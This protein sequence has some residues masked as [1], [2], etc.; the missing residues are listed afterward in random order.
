[1]TANDAQTY[2]AAVSAGFVPRL[3]GGE[4]TASEC[5]R[6]VAEY[7]ASVRRAAAAALAAH[8]SVA[9]EGPAL[10]VH[11]A[12]TA[13]LGHGLAVPSCRL[14]GVATLAALIVRRPSAFRFCSL[15]AV[16]EALDCAAQD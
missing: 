7:S 9:A 1:M 13:V 4:L 2:H 16:A 10:T 14:A 3:H 12:A 8:A 15:A 6:V 11:A 5:D